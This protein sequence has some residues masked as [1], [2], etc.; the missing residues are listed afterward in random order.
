M[1]E[2]VQ[3]LVDTIEVLCPKCGHEISIRTRHIEANPNMHLT[4]PGCGVG[5]AFDARDLQAKMRK[6][7]DELDK[8]TDTIRK[9]GQDL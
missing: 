4:C 3:M 9:P 6:V 5:I 8:L 2:G 7:R 1:R